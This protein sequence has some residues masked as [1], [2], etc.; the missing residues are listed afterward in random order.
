MY[1]VEWHEDKMKCFQLNV[2]DT[3]LL[4]RNVGNLSTTEARRFLTRCMEIPNEECPTSKIWTEVHKYRA[5]TQKR[6][7]EECE[8]ESVHYTE[9]RKRTEGFALDP[10]K[11]LIESLLELIPTE[12][13]VEAR[14]LV[15]DFIR[16]YK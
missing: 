11:G 1:E 6:A 2:A 3:E 8:V 16:N 4:I 15:D 12:N 13:A 5:T 10:G 9:K 14:K 7:R